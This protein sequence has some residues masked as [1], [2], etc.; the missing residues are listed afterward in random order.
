[1]STGLMFFSTSFGLTFFLPLGLLPVLS[2]NTPIQLSI[3]NTRFRK[4][5]KSDD[6][7]TNSTIS[8]SDPQQVLPLPEIAFEICRD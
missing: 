2:Q 8:I 6:D 5:Q 7:A 3:S 4:R 1:M